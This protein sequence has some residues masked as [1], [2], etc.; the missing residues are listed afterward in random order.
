M[1]DLA[2]K[3][4]LRNRTRTILTVLGILIGI[5]SIVALGSIAEGIDAS[6]QSSLQ[7][8]A[9]KITVQPA[10]SGL[11]SIGN[12]V[13]QEDLD[14]LQGIGGVQDIV[15]VV[16]DLGNIQSFSGPEYIVIGI[17]PDKTQY[18]VGENVE[19]YQGRPLEEGD[20]GAAMIGSTIAERYNIQVG[21]SWTV[22][23]EDF[24]IVGIIEETGISDIDASI[25][26]TLEDLQAVLETDSYYSV[27]VIPDDV[28]D[29]E[30]IAAEIEDAS[31]DLQAL[32]SQEIAR[33]ASEIVDQIRFFTF[34]IG[35]IAAFVGGL[36]VM[37]TMIMAVLERRREIGVM[38]AI[39]A[40]NRMVLTQ[41]L[42][43]SALISLIGGLGGIGLG[44]GASF[45][46]SAGFGGQITPVV[47]PVLALE[48][49]SFALFL[50]VIGGLY[51][52]RKASKLDPVEALRY[53]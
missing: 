49:L 9:S 52:A 41:I 27:Y 7:L 15:P 25:L 36:G 43:E 30:K 19:M 18:F 3:N 8:T 39:G 42:T 1:W 34:G 11:F 16:I 32:T 13:T 26:V 20:S 28:K 50:G 45:L 46:L 24:E 10:G 2:L 51:P 12:D 14:L 17:E 29:T 40:T 23:D 31:E 6:V 5:G 33:Q 21:D 38:K 37:N 48:G 44:M 35:A 4:I 53:E 47:T 22:Q